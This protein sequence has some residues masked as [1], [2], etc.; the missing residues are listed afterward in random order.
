MTM[1]N[2]E[3]YAKTDQGIRSQIIW[4]FELWEKMFG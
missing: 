1:T 4:A 2:D 3:N